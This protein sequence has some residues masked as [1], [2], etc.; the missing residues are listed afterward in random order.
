MVAT[1]IKPDFISVDGGEG[2]TGAAPLELSNSVDTPFKEGVAFV[3]D[4]LIGYDL[5]KDIKL[6]SSGKIV[7]GF[8]MFKAMALGVDICYSVRA[9]MMAVGCIQVL[10]CNHNICPTG[11]ATQNLELV[12]GLN[13][14]DK[15]ER[16]ARYQKETIKSFVELM[17]AAGIKDPNEINRYHIH[18]RVAMSFSQCYLEIFPYMKEG[19]LLHMKSTP[20]EWKMHVAMANPKNFA[21]RI[22]AVYI[23]ED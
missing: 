20:E 16:V 17:A 10:E 11:V 3:Y 6:I 13:V 18:R 22:Q 14:E 23:E 8:H 2:G 4:A 15:K 12:A 19:A 21:P 9:M 1:G 5:K 7:S